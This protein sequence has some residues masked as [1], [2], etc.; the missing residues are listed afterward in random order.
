MESKAV[1]HSL[2]VLLCMV[3]NTMDKHPKGLGTRIF[4]CKNWGDISQCDQQVWTAAW[5]CDATN[6]QRD[7]LG[8]VQGHGPSPLASSCPVPVKV[9]E[10]RS[11]LSCL[12]VAIC[13][14]CSEWK[15][16][17]RR[18]K[19]VTQHIYNK[20]FPKINDRGSELFPQEGHG[21]HLYLKTS[22]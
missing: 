10:Q 21:S 9:L 4:A 8:G 13:P 20:L 17:L 16:R 15:R 3:A 7:A 2:G 11:E 1:L 19:Q 6:A 18:A 14:N 22:R 5:Q 12:G